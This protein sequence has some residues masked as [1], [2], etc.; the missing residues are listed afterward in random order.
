LKNILELAPETSAIIEDFLNGK[1]ANLENSLSALGNALEWDLFI[2]S[3]VSRL[4]EGV[5]RK[6]LV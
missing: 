4:V 5:R 1:Y 6:A 3:R 2:G